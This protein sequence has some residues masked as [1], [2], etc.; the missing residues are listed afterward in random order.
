[1]VSDDDV[2]NRI[3]KVLKRRPKNFEEFQDFY[4]FWVEEITVDIWSYSDFTV[5]LQDGKLRKPHKL[6]LWNA[7]RIKGKDLTENELYR[8]QQIFVVERLEYLSDL[9]G[10][11]YTP[12]RW[13]D[14]D[15]PDEED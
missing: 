10:K 3:P 1:V 9:N 5:E 4:F 7:R 8:I 14:S 12:S 13:K 15:N 6:A 2:L 11:R